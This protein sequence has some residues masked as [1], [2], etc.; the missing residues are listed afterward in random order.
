MGVLRTDGSPTSA[1]GY[2]I[3]HVVVHSIVHNSM[4]CYDM[5]VSFTRYKLQYHH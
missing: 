5:V 1:G 4:I 2:A 3:Q